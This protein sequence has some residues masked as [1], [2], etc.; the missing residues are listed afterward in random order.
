ME[1]ISLSGGILRG[2]PPL[3]VGEIIELFISNENE[4]FKLIAEKIRDDTKGSVVRFL[5]TDRAIFGKLWKVVVNNILSENLENRCPYCNYTVTTNLDNCPSCQLSLKIFSE[6]YLRTHLKNTF[7]LRIKILLEA[8]KDIDLFLIYSYLNRLLLSLKNYND[9]IEFV[10]SCPKILEIFS[11]IR[12]VAPL[13][14]PVLILG[15]SGTGKELVAKAIYERSLRYSKPFIVINCAAIPETLL[16]AELFGYERGAFTGAVQSR[17]GKLELADGGTLFLDEIGELPLS[18]QAKLLRF[19]ENGEIEPLGSSISRKVDVRILAATN[20]N[21]DNEVKEGRF[22]ADLYY[23]LNVVPIE[24]P[25]LRERGI[26]KLIL[27]NYFLKKFSQEY[28]IDYK[29]LSKEAEKAIMHYT[30]PGNI[31]ELINRIRKAIVLSQNTEITPKDLGI[32]DIFSKADHKVYSKRKKVDKNSL[33]HTLK[34]NNYN[35]SKTAKT[36][37]ISRPTVY[38]LIKRYQIQCRDKN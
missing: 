3:Q 24:L 33:L 38:Q 16:E 1:G 22:R 8:L 29:K 35:I 37:G 19:L 32:D 20:K 7:F 18:L 11:I 27:A 9:D 2:G 17:P 36:L 10:G 15:E 5:I 28:F 12:K 34:S 13:D 23:R 31:R 25:P 26:D 4:R 21:L 6:E 30:W 14:I